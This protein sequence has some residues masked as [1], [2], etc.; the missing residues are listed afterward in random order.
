M[1]AI[2]TTNPAPSVQDPVVGDI[3]LTADA[4]NFDADWRI[5]DEGPGRVVYTNVQSPVDQ[6]LTLRIAQTVRPN[7]YAGSAIEL[8]AQLPTRRGCDTV[9]ELKGTWAIGDSEDATFKR[10]FPVR[11]ATTMNLPLCAEITDQ[12]VID[13]L[14]APMIAALAANRESTLQ[15]GIND[16]LHGVVEKR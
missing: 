14:L 6:P 12:V 15:G 10:M 1:S 4:L 2:L 9:I 16:L 13:S 11:I 5:I 7:V 3:S 8:A